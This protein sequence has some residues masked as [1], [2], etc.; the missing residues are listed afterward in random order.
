MY[1]KSPGLKEVT[2]P[3]T[4]SELSAKKVEIETFFCSARVRVSSMALYVCGV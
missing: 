1:K 3:L 4:G 2:V